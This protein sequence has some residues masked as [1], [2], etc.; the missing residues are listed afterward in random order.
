MYLQVVHICVCVHVVFVCMSA[1]SICVCLCV[2]VYNKHDF[3]AST[4][5]TPAPSFHFD[6]FLGLK[7]GS[8][9]EGEGTGVLSST[10]G[11]SCTV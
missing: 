10:T 11:T 7:L 1:C 4:G 8:W 3:S 6:K 9:D 2:Y 5:L